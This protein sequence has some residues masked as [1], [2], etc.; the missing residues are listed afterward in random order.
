MSNPM[1]AS[2]FDDKTAMCKDRQSDRHVV[3]PGFCNN[4]YD[5]KRGSVSPYGSTQQHVDIKAMCCMQKVISSFCKY[6]AVLD[7]PCCR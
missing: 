2:I 1:S 6:F 5:A 7:V 4:L 3:N